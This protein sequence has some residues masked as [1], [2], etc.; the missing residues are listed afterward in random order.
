M[1]WDPIPSPWEDD[2]FETEFEKQWK[3]LTEWM[4]GKEPGKG[5]QIGETVRINVVGPHRF[6]TMP[7]YPFF[8]VPLFYPEKK[9]WKIAAF[10]VMKFHHHEESPSIDAVTDILLRRIS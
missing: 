6:P 8:G 9:V 4:L 10:E 3:A 2:E 1:D 5:L 7:Q